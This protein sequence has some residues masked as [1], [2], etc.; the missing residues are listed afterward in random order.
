MSARRP[1]SPLLAD[2]DFFS[3]GLAP[4]RFPPRPV[5]LRESGSAEFAGFK[6]C[7]FSLS[8]QY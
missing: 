6:L 2:A 3:P 1:R 8:V 4:G 7:G 5:F